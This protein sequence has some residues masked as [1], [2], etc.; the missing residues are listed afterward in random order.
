M[1]NGLEIL[2]CKK[3]IRALGSIPMDYG[4]MVIHPLIG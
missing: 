4:D 1:V 3:V 2:C